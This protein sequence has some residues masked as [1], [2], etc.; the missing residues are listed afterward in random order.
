MLQVVSA[1]GD[2]WVR[3]YEALTGKKLWEFDTNPKDSVWPRTRNEVISTP[4]IYENVVYL[5]NGQDPEHGEGVGHFYAID[6]TKRGDITKSGQHL[7]L[8]QDP[9]LDLDAGHRRRPRLHLRLQ[10]LPALPRRQDRSDPTGRTTCSPRS[11]ARRFVVDGK[12]Y[13]GDEDGDVVVMAHGKE[14]KMIAEM[15]MGSAVYGTVVPANGALFLNNRSQLFAIGRQVGRVSLRAGGFRPG[16][17]Q[18]A[19]IPIMPAPCLFDACLDRAGERPVS[20]SPSCGDDRSSQLL[21]CGRARSARSVRAAQPIAAPANEWRQFRGTPTLT[22][23]S[24]ATL[25]ATLK[26]LWTYQLGEII[27]SSAAIANGVV[28]VGGGDGDLV[29]L[30][31][32]SGKLRWKYTTGNLI[33]ESSPAVGTDLV[34]VGDLAGLFH[35]VRLT[36]GSKAWTFKTGAEIKS[37]PV[38]VGDTVLIGSYDTH[39]YALDARTGALRWKKQT[40]GQVHAHAGDPGR[41]GIHC[42]L[43][44]AAARHSRERRPS[45][46]RDRRRRV[47]RCVAAA[48]RHARLSSARSTTKSWRSIWPNGVNSGATPIPIASSRSTRPRHWPGDG[49]SSAGATSSFMRSTP[50]PASPPGHLPPRARGFLSRRSPAGRVYIGSGDGRLYVLEAQTGKKLFEFDAGAGI[51]ASP[52][53]AAGRVVIGTQDGRVYVLG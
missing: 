51:S 18:Q 9:P 34:Y 5:P 4:V 11:G 15:N 25:P 16:I 3:G 24:S 23:T 28:Y 12:V 52:A 20:A 38:I 47:H 40:N 49:S 31:L 1:Q 30:D 33:G 19:V 21:R 46:V 32:A 27:E 43:R 42:R 14:K 39:L 17:N 2:G 48:R 36:D 6:A 44:L 8:R 10:R 22:G 50:P 13:L 35:A 45:D 37:S 41:P 53:I 26:V 29:A 7:A